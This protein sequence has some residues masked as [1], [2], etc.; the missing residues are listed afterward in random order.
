M[1]SVPP[2]ESVHPLMVGGAEAFMVSDAG[3]RDLALGRERGAR[4]RDRDRVDVALEG[5]FCSGLQLR[6]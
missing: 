4:D 3:A 5:H 6:R 1:V 2:D